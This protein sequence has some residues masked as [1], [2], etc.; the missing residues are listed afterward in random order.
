MKFTKWC[1]D[2]GFKLI[3]F[4]LLRTSVRFHWILNYE[5]DQSI[6]QN[7]SHYSDV[8][9]LARIWIQK[10]FPRGGGGL[11][12]NIVFQGKRVPRPFSEKLPCELLNFNFQ[13]G[14]GRGRGPDL[15]VPNDNCRKIHSII[16][17]VH[18]H[19]R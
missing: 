5:I 12:D 18:Q 14:R 10:Y 1:T 13:R 11:K 19:V 2:H 15:G 4:F 16:V 17:H 7:N 3:L 8:K 9:I 6:K